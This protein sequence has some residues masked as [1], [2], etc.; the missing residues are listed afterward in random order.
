MHHTG[1]VELA[2]WPQGYGSV[3]ETGYA[4]AV[5]NT[6]MRIRNKEPEAEKTIQLTAKEM[7]VYEDPISYFADV[8]RNK[9]Q[10]P[11]NGLYSLENNVIVCKILE[12]A[13]ESAKTGKTIFLK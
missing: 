1:F 12:A 2:V 3:C 7:G 13:R 10:V 5:N 8:V 6:T 11:K 9:I 4:I